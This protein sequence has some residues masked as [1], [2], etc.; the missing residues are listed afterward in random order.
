M[1][2]LGHQVRRLW[3]A[4]AEFQVAASTVCIN[5]WCASTCLHMPAECF[6]HS[7][8]CYSNM[9]CTVLCP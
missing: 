1:C 9:L 3:V 7:H 8:Y 6:S 4:T 5:C 2:W